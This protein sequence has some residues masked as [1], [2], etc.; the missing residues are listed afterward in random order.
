[1]VDFPFGHTIIRTYQGRGR[2]GT[3]ILGDYCLP[4]ENENCIEF[5]S[6]SIS[7]TLGDLLLCWLGWVGSP[8]QCLQPIDGHNRPLTLSV[9]ELSPK[10]RPKRGVSILKKEKEAATR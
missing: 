10:L 6:L 8:G 5:L 2:K 7:S 3:Q 1:M 9:S 4:E